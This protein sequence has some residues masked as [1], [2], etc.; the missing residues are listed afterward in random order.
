MWSSLLFL[1]MQLKTLAT[2][3]NVSV[4]TGVSLYWASA[5]SGIK[6]DTSRSVAGYWKGEGA[7]PAAG[8]D[9]CSRIEDSH[10]SATWVADLWSGKDT[11]WPVPVDS[12][13]RVPGDVTAGPPQLTI[14]D[15]LQL[16]R[17]ASR[18]WYPLCFT[19][20]V[21]VS[22]FYCVIAVVVI[23]SI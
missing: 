1:T 3:S 23:L 8:E 17:M 22:C 11:T 18:R 16:R 6:R 12:S 15:R 4:F 14:R 21:L 7:N 10:C 19:L 2:S 20:Y 9:D 13:S 5:L